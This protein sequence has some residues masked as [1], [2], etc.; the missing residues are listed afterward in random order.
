MALALIMVSLFAAHIVFPEIGGI[1]FLINAM[2]TLYLIVGLLALITPARNK[3]IE[4][5]L[6]KEET[7]WKKFSSL[8]S[9]IILG[10][11]CATAAILDFKY[12][13]GSLFLT[14]VSFWIMR[15]EYQK[16][17]DAMK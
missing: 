5:A 8:V 11:C 12:V 4:E 14:T 13:S 10:I 3:V 1:G 9:L 15:I 2:G 17:R 7:A 16:Q 6:Q